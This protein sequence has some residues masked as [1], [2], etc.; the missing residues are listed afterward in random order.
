M[1]RRMYTLVALASLALAGCATVSTTPDPQGPAPIDLT[2]DVCVEPGATDTQLRELL[3]NGSGRFILT[4]DGLLQF[5]PAR[6][7]DLDWSPASVRVLSADEL[8]QLW[9]F[10]RQLGYA[11]PASADDLAAI[12][13]DS[14]AALP[15][16]LCTIQMSAWDTRWGFMLQIG[17]SHAGDAAA[18]QLLTRLSSLSW[19]EPNRPTHTTI[20]RRYDFGPDPYADYR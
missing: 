1:S 15:P 9:T 20:P 17:P 4:A 2:M 5:G 14:S 16:G 8:T 3:P 10:I 19:L 11:D 13:A 6:S 12:T 7:R 18:L